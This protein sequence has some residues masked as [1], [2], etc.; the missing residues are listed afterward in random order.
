MVHQCVIKS[1]VMWLHIL[2]VS[3]LMCVCRT[4]RCWIINFYSIKMYGTN[5][6]IKMYIC[7]MVKRGLYLYVLSTKSFGSQMIAEMLTAALSHHT[8]SRATSGLSWNGR[9][10]WRKPRS[11]PTATPLSRYFSY[12]QPENGASKT[13]VY[14]DFLLCYF[15]WTSPYK[16]V[17][18]LETLCYSVLESRR[19]VAVLV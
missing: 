6:K 1:V 10:W 9:I 5:V 18:C 2:V 8:T 13:R 7:L 15:N 19:D 17:M 3:L 14:T 16:S 11:V 4:V 12:W